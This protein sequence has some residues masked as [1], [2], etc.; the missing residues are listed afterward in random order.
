LP[1]TPT[2]DTCTTW[3]ERCTCVNPN[4]KKGCQV[5]GP[6]HQRHHPG[7]CRHSNADP[8]ALQ[9]ATGIGSLCR[10]LRKCNWGKAWPSQ[11]DKLTYT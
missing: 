11:L 4:T 8:Q 1:Q 3:Q 2:A 9:G 5:S 7:S 10:A 6:L